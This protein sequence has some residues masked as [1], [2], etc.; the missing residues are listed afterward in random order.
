MRSLMVV[1]IGLSGCTTV[2]FPYKYYKPMI[3]WNGK[4]LGAKPEDD[5]EASACKDNKCVIMM[6]D[7]FF[8]M[9]LEYLNLEQRL[10]TLE[11]K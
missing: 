9:K 2:S 5:L 3:D 6:A 7:E 4:L 11:G 10:I 8:K 1:L